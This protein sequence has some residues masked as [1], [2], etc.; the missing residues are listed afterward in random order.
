MANTRVRTAAR[1]RFLLNGLPV[2]Y[3]RQ[4]T[5]REEITYQPIGVIGNI[6]VMEHAPTAYNVTLSCGTF[7]L[8]D[9]TLKSEGFFPKVGADSE[10]HLRNIVTQGELVAVLEDVLTHEIVAQ[11]EGVRIAGHNWTANAREV[12][13]EDIT[14]VA[15]V[16]KDAADLAANPI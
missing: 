8:L 9:K 16:M 4:V 10:Q 15:I 14:F 12:V 3:A 13:G 7:Q 2:G 1:A 11:V 5:A 6:R